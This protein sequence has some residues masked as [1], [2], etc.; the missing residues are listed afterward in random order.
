MEAKMAGCLKPSAQVA[1]IGASGYT[2]GE[3]LRILAGH[4]QVEVTWVV[5][6]QAAGQTVGDVH[7][8]LRGVHPSL[9]QKV[10]ASFEKDFLSSLSPNPA[11]HDVSFQGI[12]VLFL[13]LPHGESA[14]IMESLWLTLEGLHQRGGKAPLVID[15]SGDLRLVDPGIHEKVYGFAHCGSKIQSNFV[16]GL[17]E[18]NRSS[19]VQ[20]RWVSNPGCF[21]TAC[22]LGIAPLIRQLLIHGKVVMDCVTGSSGSGAKLSRSTHHP[23]RSESFFAYKSFGHQHLPEI[24]QTMRSLQ[25]EWDGRLVLQTHS[26]PFSRGIYATIHGE[27]SG[28]RSEFEVAKAFDDFYQDSP[29][30]RL[31]KTPPELKWVKGSQFVDLSFAVHG[32]DVMVNVAL[33][34]LVKGAA[35][36]A[37]QNMNLAM[38]W[39][40]ISGLNHLGM[41]V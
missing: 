9:A 23:E 1:V 25:P 13:A 20:S 32:R 2:G 35:G 30:I 37:V 11:E 26:G 15:L 22:A 24:E 7:P 38:G 18:V 17:S 6:H 40:E 5:G 31:G 27:L 8:P 28:G 36:Q 3:L 10:I 41:V 16:Y 14:R 29:F 39:P 21:A 19:I 34:N 33:D 4:P 12:D